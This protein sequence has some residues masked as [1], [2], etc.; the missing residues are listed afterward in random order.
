[1]IKWIEI[2]EADE[3]S[4]W[5]LNSS[6][7]SVDSLKSFHFFSFFSILWINDGINKELKTFSDHEWINI[8]RIN[9]YEKKGYWTFKQ[10]K[11]YYFKLFFQISWNFEL[12]SITKFSL[13]IFFREF[14]EN[15]FWLIIEKERHNK[16]RYFGS[17]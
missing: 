15:L 16:S 17:P 6:L 4:K 10:I 13:K 5:F 7:N 3:I 2:G 11:V 1:M 9:F 14:A 8:K 12:F